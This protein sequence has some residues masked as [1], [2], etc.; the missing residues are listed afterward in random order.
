MIEKLEKFFVLNE[1][2][3]LD[4]W[5]MKVKPALKEHAPEI[6]A[7]SILCVG[8]AVSVYVGASL[9]IKNAKVEINL[10]PREGVKIPV[11]EIPNPF[12]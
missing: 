2:Y 1:K 5:Q 9:A 3:I 11:P 8:V 4:P 7:G 10:I 12:K 6:I